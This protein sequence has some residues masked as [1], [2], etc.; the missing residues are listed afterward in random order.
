MKRLFQFV[1]SLVVGGLVL[2]AVLRQFDFSQM[3]VALRHA[4]LNLL[5]FG[6]ALMICAY[7]VRGARW[8]IWETSLSYWD[9]LRL[10]LIGFMGN[11]VLPARLGEILRAHCTSSKTDNDRG[12]TA[13]LASI[14]AERI[15]D[16]LVLAVFGIIGMALVPVDRRLRWSLLLVSL[17]FAALT[18][19]VVLS[20]HLHERI[21][22][23][24]A[25]ANRKFPG[26]VTAFVQQKANHILNGL[27]PLG[28]GPRMTAAISVTVLIWAIEIG[29]YY[30]VGLAVWPGMSVRFA[31]LLLVVVNFASLIPL[32]IGGIGTIEAVALAFLVSSGVPRYPALTMILL[33]HADQYFFTTIA[34]GI[35]YFA[36][37]FYRLPLR[38]A[39]NE[40]VPGPP[41]VSSSAVLEDTK[42][43]LNQLGEVVD[44]KPSRRDETRLS[45]VIPAYNEQARLPRTVLETIH[46]CTNL[47]LDFELIIADD[48]SRDA[49]LE[50]ARLFEGS[51]VRVRALA[52]P[53]MGKGAA[54]RMGM[55]NARGGAVLFMDADGATRISEILKLLAAI[56]AGDDVAI[57]SRVIQCPG[58]VEVKTPIYRKII[59]RVFAFFVNMFA[60]GGI[61]DTQCGFKMFRREAA[62][63]IFSRQK[64]AGFAFD[65]EILFIARRL[66]LSVTEIPVNW[67]A[68][69]GSK[70]NLV[71]DSMKMLWDITHIRWLHRNSGLYSVERVQR[72]DANREIFAGTTFDAAKE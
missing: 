45:I 62:Q 43:S 66:G 51:D 34:G 11:N 54:V 23:W 49:T 27:L 1:V 52:C 50:L 58:E 47:K 40:V 2:R 17:G 16:G 68:Q 71:T 33:Q 14:G 15:L 12:R 20:I 44:L 48:G 19:A 25:A 32:T 9:S 8:R 37:G 31:L 28:T 59:G 53:H 3:S 61:A 60:I 5:V 72:R 13:A 30:C 70:V 22:S 35:F 42:S 36:G 39:K 64:M 18:S 10:I 21:R 56:D 46:W 69:P 57:G 67:V 6:L 29:F 55:L 4:H 41:P 26:H 38:R 63:A 65:V 7:L 24:I